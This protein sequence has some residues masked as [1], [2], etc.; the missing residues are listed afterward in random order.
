MKSS[1]FIRLLHNPVL[2]RSYPMSMLQQMADSYPYSSLPYTLLALKSGMEG[3]ENF[4]YSLSRAALRV[5]DRSFLYHLI[6]SDWSAATEDTH[7]REFASAEAPPAQPQ[8]DVNEPSEKDISD[9]PAVNASQGN[10][11]TKSLRV[12]TDDAESASRQ[13]E[14][15]TPTDVTLPTPVT[16]LPDEDDKI[17][18]LP[19][20]D[21]VL[22]ALE[23]LQQSKPEDE[24]RKAAP[25]TQVTEQSHTETGT[26]SLH[27]IPDE[28]DEHSF[29]E[30][31][32]LLKARP[33][34]TLIKEKE[35]YR[36]ESIFEPA[37]ISPPSDTLKEIPRESLPAETPETD[38]PAQARKS[39]T[40]DSMLITE[41]L[42]KI[43]E[44]QKK[45][46]RAISAYEHLSL[47]YP[48]KKAYF[49]QRIEALKQQLR[50]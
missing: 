31:L 21:E 1:E 19:G 27:Q 44:Q 8:A 34:D 47:K 18:D 41:T 17:F 42:A 33:A 3:D 50:T 7:T 2:L 43:Y 25:L 49:A 22:R 20:K 29:T 16:E 12:E 5:Y 9:I 40:E 10:M 23:S 48:D 13:Q 26:P 28:S 30:W 35:I 36:A 14:G 4:E 38:L 37:E 45:Y 32:H 15:P 11:P 24:E 39:L 6:H 46:A